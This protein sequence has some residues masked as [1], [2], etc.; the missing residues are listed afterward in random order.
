MLRGY[1]LV[2]AGGPKCFK[3]MC[4][5]SSRLLNEGV[6]EWCLVAGPSGQIFVLIRPSPM[7]PGKAMD[8]T[9]P[10]PFSGQIIAISLRDLMLNDG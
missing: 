3:H 4:C 2:A 7:T 6:L 1:R 10:V 5:V 9:Q 8:F